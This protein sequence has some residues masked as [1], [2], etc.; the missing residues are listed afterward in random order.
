MSIGA[1]SWHPVRLLGLHVPSWDGATRVDPQPGERVGSPGLERVV[2]PAMKRRGTQAAGVSSR[3]A[4]VGQGEA[5]S[6]GE[7]TTVQAGKSEGPQT[8]PWRTLGGHGYGWG[9]IS[10]KHMGAY[11]AGGNLAPVS[12]WWWAGGWTV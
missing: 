2:Q 9:L 4:M 11:L 10:S 5:K 8:D 6:L 3:V 1:G 7:V 12:P